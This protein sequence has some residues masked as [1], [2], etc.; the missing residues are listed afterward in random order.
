M[1]RRAYIV[2][3]ARTPVGRAYR[4]AFN[5]PPA[6]TLAATAISAAVG[7]AGVDP[8]LIDD[9]IIGSAIPQGNQQTI[10]RTA[11]MRAGLRMFVSGMTLDRR[12]S[13][14]LMAIATAAKQVIVDRMGVVF[15]GAWNRSR[16]SKPRR[17]VSAPILRSRR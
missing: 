2:S 1:D 10:G 11:T 6:P 3:T 15:V 9:C 17:C 16:W 5:A 4:G 12:C 13:S 8:A 7:R 14:G